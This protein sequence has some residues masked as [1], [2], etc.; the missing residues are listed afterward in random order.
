MCSEPINLNDRGQAES[1]N[2]P[3]LLYFMSLLI[4]KWGFCLFRIK[5][6]YIKSKNN[7]KRSNVWK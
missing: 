5:M 4:L 3:A 2:C 7:S 6:Q 1:M